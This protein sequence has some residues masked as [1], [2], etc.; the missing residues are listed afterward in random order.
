M[1]TRHALSQRS[2]WIKGD[3]AR[4][5]TI[6]GWSWIGGKRRWVAVT[7]SH[8][9]TYTRARHWTVTATYRKRGQGDTITVTVTNPETTRWIA[10]EA[11]LKTIAGA[12]A[13]YETIMEISH[14]DA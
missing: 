12:I 6:A 3:N 9:G 13:D 8:S 5:R 7:A 10:T 14:A 11:A 2:A 1:K 4:T